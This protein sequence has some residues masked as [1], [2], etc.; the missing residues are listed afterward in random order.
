MLEIL[1]I[2]MILFFGYHV[3]AIFKPMLSRLLVKT[4]VFI[5]S[6]PLTAL[7]SFIFLIMTVFVG[8]IVVFS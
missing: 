3:F 1:I 2:L 7:F 4:A 6:N 8:A 5:G